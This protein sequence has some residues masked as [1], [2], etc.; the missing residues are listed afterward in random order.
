MKIDLLIDNKNTFLYNYKNKIKK[1]ITS[2]VKK[3][4]G[5]G[6]KYRFFNKHNKIKKGDIMFV[7][8]CQKILEENELKKHKLNLVIHPS[9]LPKGKGHAAL[10]NEILKG[11]S[12]FYITMF[13]ASADMDGGNICMVK[14]FRLVGHELHD[15]IRYKQAHL[16][17]KMIYKFIKNYPNIKFIK[18]KGK[19]TFYKKRTE[20]DHELNINKSIKSQFNLLRISCNKNYPAFFLLNKKKYILNINAEST[21]KN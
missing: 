9:K 3:K 5:W 15:E 14:K 18:Q 20:K 19:S 8:G 6:I 7:I 10:F 11:K 17:L 21:K 2:S 13:N 16:T 12:T 1:L 4:G